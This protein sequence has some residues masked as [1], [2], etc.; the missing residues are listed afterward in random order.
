MVFDRCFLVGKGR[1]P[2]P[3]GAT[4]QDGEG[5]EG[6]CVTHFRSW[7]SGKS[8]H[9][10]VNLVIIDAVEAVFVRDRRGGDYSTVTTYSHIVRGHQL[11]LRHFPHHR[12]A[13]RRLRRRRRGGSR[14]GRRASSHS[15]VGGANFLPDMYLR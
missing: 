1:V 15:W 12:T 3:R 7:T 11:S 2:A 10:H 4:A 14:G 5:G 13:C 6:M 9:V 8:H